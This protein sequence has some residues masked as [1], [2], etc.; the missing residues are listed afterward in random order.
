MADPINI[1]DLFEEIMYNFMILRN[2]YI[3]QENNQEENVINNQEDYQEEDYQEEDYQEDNIQEENY[4]Q[5]INQEEDMGNIHLHQNTLIINID[6]MVHVMNVNGPMNHI[7]NGYN[8]MDN[9]FDQM[10]NAQEIEFKPATCDLQKCLKMVSNSEENSK[11]TICLDDLGK[12]VCSLDCKHYYHKDC[13]ESW[14]KT[15]GNCPI[16]KKRVD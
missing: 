13:I 16:C 2:N 1:D 3:Q 4:Q 12:E 11:C 10:F 8:N 6:G 9:I 7:V 15:S 14:L 5:E